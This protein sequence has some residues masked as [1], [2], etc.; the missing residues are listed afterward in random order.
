MVSITSPRSVPLDIAE[1]IAEEVFNQD[2]KNYSSVKT[3]ALVSRTFLEASRRVLYDTVKLLYIPPRLAYGSSSYSWIKTALTSSPEIARYVRKLYVVDRTSVPHI[4]KEPT[5]PS[6]LGMFQNI[7]VLILA[8]FQFQVLSPDLQ[9]SLDYILK[10]PVLE[11]VTLT[12]MRNI[13]Y[14]CVKSLLRIHRVALSDAKFLAPI[15]EDEIECQ[16]ELFASFQQDGIRTLSISNVTFEN[17]QPFIDALSSSRYRLEWLHVTNELTLWAWSELDIAKDILRMK[18]RYLTRIDIHCCLS[19]W[20]NHPGTS[21]DIGNLTRLRTISL[22]TMFSGNE[23]LAGILPSLYT[24]HEGNKIQEIAF[25]AE[26]SCPYINFDC[27]ELAENLR[28]LDILLA[29]KKRFKHLQ[30]V[31]FFGVLY[32]TPTDGAELLRSFLPLLHER[33]VLQI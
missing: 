20:I 29:D 23:A 32:E 18:S 19:S 12:G 16:Q 3:C 4:L 7:R 13:P 2:D 17:L 6:I 5:F 26:K 11:D 28:D 22:F 9:A 24:A 10:A 1:L 21:I 27:S 25:T 14:S 30:K 15:T 8:L 33:G 31:Y